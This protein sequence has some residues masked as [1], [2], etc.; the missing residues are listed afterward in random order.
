[1]KSFFKVLRYFMLVFSMSFVCVLF[2]GNDASAAGKIDE[3]ATGKAGIDTTGSY[4]NENAAEPYFYK[5]VSGTEYY[6]YANQVLTI[7][8]NERTKQG[9]SKL[10]LDTD[11]TKLA[12]IRAREISVAFSHTRTNGNS[13]FE[14]FNDVANSGWIGE[15]IAAGYSSAESVMNGW[16]NST[17]H[18]E[19]IMSTN[20]NRI[21]IGVCY[22]PNSTYGYYW[23]QIFSSGSAEKTGAKS[24]RVAYNTY[25]EC[26]SSM[27]TK[28]N[29]CLN[30]SAV[31]SR[32]YYYKKYADVRNTYYSSD[33]GQIFYHFYKKGMP[34]GRIGYKTFDVMYYRN[35]Y[36]DLRAK[37]GTN[38]KK[39]YQ[40]YITTGKKEGRIGA[41]AD[42]TFIPIT[43]YNGVDYQLVY[44]FNYYSTHYADVAKACGK[45]DYATLAHFVKTGMKENRRG[46]SG[47]DPTSYR[48]EYKDIRAKYRLDY[49]QYYLHYINVGYKEGRNPTGCTEIK[50]PIT[51]YNGVEYKLVYNYKYYINKYPYISQKYGD[52]DVAVLKHFIYSGMDSGKKACS[53]F[54]VNIYKTRY[55]DLLYDKYGDDLKKYYLDYI[56]EGYKAGRKGI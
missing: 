4:N 7:V 50:S 17:G 21:G 51:K 53:T 44:S 40:H 47:F 5:P 24:E 56:N 3:P 29:D 32:S 16:M 37:Y 38:L 20:Y 18:K 12:M 42:G 28:T 35:K 9:L 34:L 33:G 49:K 23:V 36:S 2:L 14:V 10:V 43:V 1:M 31:F 8:N 25:V 39:Y 11:M 54:D 41:K 13:C 19:N 52:D 45:N 48:Y 22:V 26:A 30:C 55:K 6:D 15:N 27:V 46:K